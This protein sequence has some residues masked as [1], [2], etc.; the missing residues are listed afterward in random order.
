[1]TE[2]RVASSPGVS[3]GRNGEAARDLAAA[4]TF[5]LFQRLES[6]PGGLT[7]QSAA[8]RLWQFGENLPG[9][10]SDDG[11]LV[12]A[13]S[14]VK[15]PFI[16]LLAALGVVFVAVRDADGAVTVSVVVALT[17]GLRL[18]QHW[19]SARAAR[20]LRAQVRTTATV[21]RRAA[22]GLDPTDRE[23]PVEDIVRGDVVLL[24]PGDV[25]PADL[26]VLSANDLLID[27]AIL[28]GESMPVGKTPPDNQP[29][30]AAVEFGP[31]TPSVCFAG[32]DVMSGTATAVAIATGAATYRDELVRT[33]GALRPDSSFD[34]GVR[35]VGVTLIRFMLVMA[36]IVLLAN[37][38]VRGDW[39]QAALFAVTVAIGL[40]PE[41]LPVIVAANLARGANRL[42][43]EK[44]IVSRLEAIQDL[45]AM[46]VLCVDKTGTLTDDRV[47]YARSV[48]PTGSDDPEVGEIAYLAAYFQ[49]YAYNGLDEA[50]LERF[51]GNGMG[52]I[53]EAAFEK[54]GEVGFDPA[55]RRNTVIVRRQHFE[56]ILISRGDPD[57]ILRRCNRI[58]LGGSLID[59]DEDARAAAADVARGYGEQGMR[60]LAVA[61]RI[62]SAQ[63]DR[64][65]ARD[66][67]RLVLLG[68]LGFVDP[69]RIGTDAAVATLAGHGVTVKM[70]T[71]DGPSVSRIVAAEAGLT[72]GEVVVGEQ[73]D[74]LADDELRELA[75][76]TTVFAHLS[77][78]HKARIVAALR[79]CGHTVGF[80]GEGVNDVPALRAAD[81]GIAADRATDSVKNAA[82]LLL[83][84]DDLGVLADGV[85][86]GRRTLA[87]TMKYVKITASSNFGDVLTV[88][89]ASAF[90]PFLPILPIQLLVQNLLYDAAQLA[91][92]WDRVDHDYLTAPRR[93]QPSGLVGFML[94][95]GPLS[96][97]FDLATFG[98]LWWFFHAGDHPAVFQT[99][100][101][102]EGLLSQVLVVLVLRAP[103]W[104][105]QGARAPLLVVS[106]AAAA[107]GIGLLLPIS[108]LAA[109][110]H[111]APLGLGYLPWL[112]VIV[113]ANLVAA[114]L[115][116]R[117]YLRRHP[118]WR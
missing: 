21:R 15:S 67:Q 93:W 57:E 75:Q 66:E 32:T 6:S 114:Q 24:S 112:V 78:A 52:A 41:L 53:A 42:A 26:R 29:D 65:G 111:L 69:V 2:P 115:I 105:W 39:S 3:A 106:A 108:P 70:L 62:G 48:D 11:F 86:E 9:R 91:L 61:A 13:R 94:W 56:H 83:L 36:P 51:E 59:L 44:V 31:E 87:N 101:F 18:W 116:K 90:L 77:P 46:D 60:V 14:A 5:T 81:A 92:P 79:A 40:T 54:V 4:S 50:I 27:Q 33:A 84:D 76:R 47:V 63:H 109:R 107:V 103:G 64:Y 99:G 96:S 80:L 12:S 104:P 37:G 117:C 82:D 58:R 113:A 28:S 55:R 22:V 23:V 8:D 19:R 85:I 1:V 68:F 30:Y 49:D 20:A 95:F 71:G 73:L 34:L 10:Y 100:L 74:G 17:V 25:V 43:S 89:V 72:V 16:A 7:E 102:L 88:L 110:L 45:G 97:L 98:V 38:S 35:G 118:N